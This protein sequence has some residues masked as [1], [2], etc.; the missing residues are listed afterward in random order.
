MNYKNY[1]KKTKKTM[2]SIEA[3]LEAEYG[4]VKMEWETTL[5]LLADNLDL[6]DS[7]KEILEKTG[8]FDGGTWK[9]NPL[10]STMKDCQATVLKLT[11]HLGISPWSKSKINTP[12]EDGTDDFLE[13]LTS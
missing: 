6:L 8:I 9:K 4:E 12:E 2:K 7:C 13:N 11:Q 10:L 1:S 5:T 3:Y